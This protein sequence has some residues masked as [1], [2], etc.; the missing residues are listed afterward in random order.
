MTAAAGVRVVRHF[1]QRRG[2]TIGR[3]RAGFTLIE[4]LFAMVL[5]GFS[6]LGVQAVVTDRLLGRV[7]R[8]DARATALA[9]RDDRLNAAQADPQYDEIAGRFRGVEETIPGFPGFL[10]TTFVTRRADHTV[11][12]VEVVTPSRRD[13]VAST[14]VIGMQ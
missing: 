14:A 5:L 13:T 8:E 3:D 7:A 2:R 6:I 9:L 4:V 11:V 12:T 10:R 1:P